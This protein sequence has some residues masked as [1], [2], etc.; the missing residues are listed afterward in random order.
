MVTICLPRYEASLIWCQGSNG[1]EQISSQS[2]P[3]DGP[4]SHYGQ[5]W[6]LGTSK[7]F[8]NKGKPLTHS[9]H[10]EKTRILGIGCY[11]ASLWKKIPTASIIYPPPPTSPFVH[12]QLQRQCPK[13]VAMQKHYNR[14]NTRSRF[15]LLNCLMQSRREH[16]PNSVF[17]KVTWCTWASPSSAP[18]KVKES[19]QSTMSWAETNR[20]TL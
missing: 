12:Y 10:L 18:I 16:H 14:P 8:R 20:P 2:M 1:R 6:L 3:L 19:F 4:L 5:G 13:G 9:K 7:K 15:L 17:K 11:H